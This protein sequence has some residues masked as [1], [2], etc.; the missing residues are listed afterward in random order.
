[1]IRNY[2]T[3]DEAALYSLWNTAGVKQGFAPLSMEKFHKL[4]TGH[5][6]FSPEFTFVMEKNNEICGFVNGCTGDHIPKGDVRGYFS[7]LIL[8][9]AEDTAENSRLLLE[10]L[11]YAFRKAGKTYSAATF[12]NPIRLPW[13]IP[14]TKGHQH[15]NAPGIPLDI[16][17]HDRMLSAG[18]RESTRECAMYLKLANYKAPSWL[19]EKTAKMAQEGYTVARYDPARH[20]GLQ[21]MVDALNNPMW[22]VEIPEAGKNGMNL[23]V[24]LCG[25]TCAG[26]TGPVYPEETGRGYFAGLAV[27]PQYERHG[28]GTLL[29]YRLLQEEKKA[30]SQYMSLFTGENNPARFIYLG[31]GFRVVRTF[32]VLLKEL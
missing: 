29:F 15:N 17:L 13:I 10:A 8:S 3:E 25:T 18:Y 32:G 14:G 26:F 16:P 23:L 31:A 2:K 6:D 27:A 28:L 1:M 24:G 21:E 19:P 22:S 9:A 5:P 7:C 12:F 20:R 11:E 30:G 4:L